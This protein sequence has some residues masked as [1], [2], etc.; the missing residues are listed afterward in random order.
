MI[1][2]FGWEQRM[3]EQID[4]KRE[5]EVVYLAKKMIY[6]MAGAVPA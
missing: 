3:E 6:I 4:K 1:K 2:L 5:E